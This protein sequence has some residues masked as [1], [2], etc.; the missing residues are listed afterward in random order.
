MKTIFLL[1]LISF[2]SYA[3]CQDD[4]VEIKYAPTLTEIGK[5]T[6]EKVSEKIDRDGGKLVSSDGR[7]ELIMPPDAVSKKTNVSIRSVVNTLSPG[8]GD[9][10]QLEPSGISFQKPV[11][12]IFHYSAKEDA[13]M[14]EL[15]NIAWQ[16]EKGQW[17]V[18]DSCVV[19]T[20][21]R[22]V[23]GS[24]NHFSTWVF[25]DYFNLTPTTA[26]VKVGNKL[27]LEV[28]CTYPGGL[29]D[30]FKTEML[31]K[32]KFSSYVN[33]IRGGNAV[34]GT[35]SSVLGS[36]DHRFLDYTAPA[37]VP[38]N[39][40]V[41]LSVEASNI[42]FNRKT[43]SKLKLISN[44]LIFDK[45]YEI[46]VIGYNKQHTGTCTL[47]GVD[48]STFILQLNGSRSKVVDIQNMN[49]KLTISGC[50][51]KVTEVNAGSAIGPVNILGATKIDIV[52]ASPPQKPYVFIR[53]YFI[54]NMGAIPAMVGDPCGGNVGNRSPVMALPAV[55]MVVLFEAKDEPYTVTKEGTD[56]GF[57][58]K[59]KPVKEDQ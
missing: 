15:R 23:T 24:I 59:V 10:Y 41:A 55:P 8:K 51:C 45:S 2:T 57:E 42:T 7:M 9:A 56:N 33:G 37:T 58:I 16:D 47:S 38:D 19:D 20:V 49:Y 36:N 31:Q 21:A 11:R 40:P 22:T 29:S 34:V 52:P 46:T 6:G 43:Y 27:R 54:R 39:N 14:P 48:S 4:S 30:N 50:P 3:F 18:L 26:R 17:Y 5:P 13:A 25:F 44:I 32:I 1:W 53:I 35:A 12:M 28:I